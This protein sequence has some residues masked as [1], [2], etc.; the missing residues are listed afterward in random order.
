[1][2]EFRVVLGSNKRSTGE[3]IKHAL[4]IIQHPLYD[5]NLGVN[6]I[7][8]VLLNEPVVFNS[9][10]NSIPISNPDDHPV[11]GIKATVSG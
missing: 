5:S 9:K 3:V 4:R 8:L 7:A 6:N 11:V 10:I 2:R 1:M